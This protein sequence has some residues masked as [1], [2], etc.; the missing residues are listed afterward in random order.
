MPAPS[1][2]IPEAFRTFFD[3][4]A[5][6]PPGLA[7]LDRAVKDHVARRSSILADAV[8]PLVLPLKD[9]SE[10]KK[11]AACE[12]L[13]GGP[14]PISIVT[15]AGQLPKALEAVR[16]V[17]PQLRVAAIELKTTT[18]VE[19]YTRELCQASQA[20]GIAVYAELTAAQVADGVLDIVEGT[21]MRLKYRTGGIEAHMFPTPAELAAVITAAVAKDIPFKLTAGL[22]KGVRYTNT[23]TGFTHHGFLNVAVAV[24]IAQK[25]A[26]TEQLEAALAETDAGRLVD[27][28]RAQ[29]GS[30]R[31]SFTSF[32]TCSVAEPA[33]NLERLWLIPAGATVLPKS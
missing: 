17:G 6:F 25:G 7:A 15:P 22:H 31:R 14:V 1:V 12:D 33:E 30:W 19:N 24:A 10:A 4:A 29:P 5:V 11:L 20:T 27:Q 23:C 13:S 2:R 26:G 3:D 28:Y 18:G 32:G 16:A 9:V 8:G 21:A